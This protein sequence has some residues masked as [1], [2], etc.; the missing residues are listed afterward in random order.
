[1]PQRCP[2]CRSTDLRPASVQRTDTWVQRKLSQAYR[3]RRCGRRSWRLEPAV[4]TLALAGTLVVGAPLGFLGVHLVRQP[5]EATQP[6]AEDPF[7]NL[8]RRAG[9]GEVAAQL[10]L[11]RRH[12]DG[13]GTPHRFGDSNPH[14]RAGDPHA[15]LSAARRESHQH[16]RE[17]RLGDRRGADADAGVVP[18]RRAHLDILAREERVLSIIKDELKAQVS[19][20]YQRYRDAILKYDEGKLPKYGTLW[21]ILYPNVMLE[22]Y[23]HCL[24]VSTLVPVSPA[25]TLNVVEFYYPEE[26][27]LFEREIVDAHQAAYAEAATEDMQICALLHRGRRAL[28]LAGEDDTGPYHSPHEDGMVHFHVGGGIVADSRPEHEYAE[29]W[30]K[31]EGLLRALV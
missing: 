7:A 8:S 1:M 5:P 31:A 11:G 25:Q 22:W 13:D 3:C 29:T 10:E 6:V 14:S 20:N 4:V 16:Q 12:E 28:W 23:P 17:H 21:C 24:V 2:H 26:I 18:A 27:A 30:H 9:Q 19:P 15:A